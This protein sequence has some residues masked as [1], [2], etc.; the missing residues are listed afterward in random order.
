MNKEQI[1]RNIKNSMRPGIPGACFIK[2]LNGNS[3][4]L[5]H[6][7][8]D[9]PPKILP[10]PFRK[11]QENL[12]AFVFRVSEHNE[13]NN[14]LWEREYKFNMLNEAIKDFL[15]NLSDEEIASG[16]YIP[17][18]NKSKRLTDGKDMFDE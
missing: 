12:G 8:L 6:S 18:D 3:R 10:W 1:Y 9:M 13:V 14:T 15:R 11:L 17:D 7:P 16:I 5:S 4:L 2:M